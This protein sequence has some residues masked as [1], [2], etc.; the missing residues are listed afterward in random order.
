MNIQPGLFYVLARVNRF[1]MLGAAPML[2]RTRGS[3]VNET[4]VKKNANKRCAARCITPSSPSSSRSSSSFIPSLFFALTTTGRLLFRGLKHSRERG[5]TLP[6]L[7]ARFGLLRTSCIQ[8]KNS[9]R[10]W[11]LL[12]DKQKTTVL[13]GRFFSLLLLYFC[14]H[15]RL[16]NFYRFSMQHTNLCAKE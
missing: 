4:F 2:D 9:V 8:K 3:K 15:T 5:K 6:I 7:H 11:Y 1:L 14:I 12:T 13:A 10:V 16:S